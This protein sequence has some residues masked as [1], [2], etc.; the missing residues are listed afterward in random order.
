[1]SI[2]QAEGWHLRRERHGLVVV[3]PCGWWEREAGTELPEDQLTPYW[4][5]TEIYRAEK[6]VRA[7]M[8]LD[9]TR[10]PWGRDPGGCPEIGEGDS[11]DNGYVTATDLPTAQRGNFDG[12]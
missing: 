3:F 8:R 12:A 11:R 1:M 9:G 10:S 7:P 5:R 6:N 4:P 2:G